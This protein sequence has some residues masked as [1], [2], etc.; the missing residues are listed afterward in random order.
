MTYD[1]YK[2]YAEIVESG[3]KSSPAYWAARENYEDSLYLREYL[4]RSAAQA[5]AATMM[6]PFDFNLDAY[7]HRA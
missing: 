6:L 4:T 2:T 3:D 7:E 1:A 5:F